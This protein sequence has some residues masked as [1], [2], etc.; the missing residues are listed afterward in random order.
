MQAAMR[1]VPILVHDRDGGRRILALAVAAG[2]TST[3]L[4]MFALQNSPAL[5]DRNQ[6][7]LSAR[8]IPAEEG[9][10]DSARAAG[11]LTDA[12][13]PSIQGTRPRTLTAPPDLPQPLSPDDG[14]PGSATKVPSEPP[15]NLRPGSSAT[16]PSAHSA[17]VPPLR[18]DADTV[19]S[20]IDAAKSPIHDAA[21]ASGQS[22]TARTVSASE[23][24]GQDIS[25]AA[26]EDCIAPNSYGSLLSAPVLLFKALKGDCK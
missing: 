11:P 24:L 6:P 4:A 12:P 10:Q 13:P 15:T 25:E 19:R 14:L 3:I 16:E 9:P 18:L 2:I 17:D 23:R 7:A 21:D 5:V 26:I 22:L 20:A 8:L 1:H